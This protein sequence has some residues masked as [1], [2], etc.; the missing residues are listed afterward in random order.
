MTASVTFWRTFARARSGATAIEYAFLL[1]LIAIT[2]IGALTL[3]GDSLV[4]VFAGVSSEVTAAE[5]KA[6]GNCGSGDGDGSA[7]CDNK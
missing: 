3:V 7:V 1:A 5:A 4:T 2:L 6:L